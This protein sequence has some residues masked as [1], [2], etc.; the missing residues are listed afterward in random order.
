MVTPSYVAWVPLA[1]GE[2]YYGY[3]YY[4]PG[5]V[6][7]TTININTVTVNREYR[8]ARNARSVNMVKRDTF[9]T[10]RR[11]FIQGEKN[12]FL[13]ERREGRDV[14]LA[15]PRVRPTQPVILVPPDVRTDTNKRQQPP[16]QEQVRQDY[17]GVRRETPPQVRPSQPAPKVPST[18]PAVRTDRP[19]ETPPMVRQDQQKPPERVIKNQP[20]T[21]KNE[22][23]MVKEREGSVFRSQPPEN[24]P[25][26]KIP[27]PRPIIRTKPVKPQQTNGQNPKKQQGDDGQGPESG[28]GIRRSR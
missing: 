13:G 18:P 1:P 26:K 17:P 5:S 10:G 7:I 12:P 3:G 2:V 20:D 24:L 28:G 14:A 6:N 22:R 4:G 11:E 8:N 25:V 15:P 21:L 19:R 16:K 9:G 23:R 27:E